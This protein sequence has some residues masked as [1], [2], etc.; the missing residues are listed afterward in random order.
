MDTYT[1]RPLHFAHHSFKNYVMERQRLVV[2]WMPTIQSFASKYDDEANTYDDW[3]TPL[4]LS[5]P[6]IRIQPPDEPWLI[7]AHGSESNT[8]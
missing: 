6:H 8:S 7:L 2:Q 3:T 1:L 5:V 4:S